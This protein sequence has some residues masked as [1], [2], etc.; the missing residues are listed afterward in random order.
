MIGNQRQFR[1]FE[2][3]FNIPAILIIYGEHVCLV[4]KQA[5]EASVFIIEDEMIGQMA[6]F[7]FD[8]LWKSLP[9][10]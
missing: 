1:F 10:V 2:D 6:T 7:L 3:E 8:A 5:N 9:R 4:S